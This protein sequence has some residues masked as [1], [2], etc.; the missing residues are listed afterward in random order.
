MIKEEEILI[1]YL[2]KYHIDKL[3]K[4]LYELSQLVHRPTTVTWN[5]SL[6]GLIITVGKVEE[7]VGEIKKEG[8]ELEIEQAAIQKNYKLPTMRIGFEQGAKWADE[9]PRKDEE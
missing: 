9:H 3:E 5:C 6:G 2:K 1:N 7:L 4:I 8:R